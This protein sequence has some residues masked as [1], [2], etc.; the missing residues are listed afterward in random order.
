MNPDSE[1]AD[2]VSTTNFQDLLMAPEPMQRL[3]AL[4]ELEVALAS[5][6]SEPGSRFAQEAQ[7]FADRG[8]PYYDREDRHFQAWVRKAVSYWERLHGARRAD[9][10]SSL[11][12]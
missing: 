6:Q 3:R 2:P 10:A 1:Q 4:H 9:T 12:G 7:R 5:Y 11:A 8:V